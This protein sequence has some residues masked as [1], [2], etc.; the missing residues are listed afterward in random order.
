MA[1][2]SDVIEC[3]GDHERDTLPPIGKGKRGRSADIMASLEARLQRVELAM[4]DDR[5]KVMDMDQR[6]DGLEGGHEEFHMEMRGILNS[7]AD[8]WKAQMD[9]L[10]NS[11]QAEI[12]AIKEEIKEVKGDWSLC[13]M[14][15]E[16]KR[17]GPQ[18]LA[19]AIS[20]VESLINFKEGESS[21]FMPNFEK[22]DHDIGGG[23]HE[24]EQKPS[25]PRH[26][27]FNKGKRNGD[28][29]KLSCFLC[30][31]NHF[32]RD[33]PKR[34]KLS[35]HI[36]EDEEEPALRGSQGGII[37]I[38]QCNPSQGGQGQSTKEGAHEAKQLGLQLKKEQGWIK[39]INTEARPIY[40]VARDMR[41]HIGD[42]CGQVDFI[43]VPMDDYP[44]VLGM[45]LLDRSKTLSAMQLSKEETN[46]EIPATI[47][48]KSPGALKSAKGW[49]ADMAKAAKR[50]KSGRARTDK[51][52]LPNP[53]Q[54]IQA[55]T[56]GGGITLVTDP[57]ERRQTLQ[58][59]VLM[60]IRGQGQQISRDGDEG[61]A[62]LGGRECYKPTSLAHKLGPWRAK[63]SQQA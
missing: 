11:L 12:A 21:S 36:R 20:I 16:V 54:K 27:R 35:A 38:A 59:R 3:G 61:V 4:A 48:T 15:L 26:G 57:V 44:I 42:W 10:K 6:I 2:T 22:S 37:A 41:L 19:T 5:D 14:A 29:P 28:K 17:R 23:D 49:H 7:L 52:N 63:V 60:A 53:N 18:D 45:E 62:K 31:G 32:A 55:T 46:A 50:M 43:M 58:R 56:R 9:A 51:Q 24:G 33:C 34:A 40:G 30:D 25:S 39:A 47:L 13:K 8:S 1:I